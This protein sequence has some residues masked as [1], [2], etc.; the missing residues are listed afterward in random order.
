[1]V[2]KRVNVKDKNGERHTIIVNAGALVDM[3]GEVLGG[4]EMWRDAMPE[5]EMASRLNSL[6]S[7]LDDYCQETGKLLDNL[8][9]VLASVT[10]KGEKDQPITDQMRVQLGVLLKSCHAMQTSYCWS[11][12]NCPPERQVQCPAFPNHG[13][14]CW[15]IDY[16]WCNGQMQGDALAKIDKCSQCLVFGELRNRNKRSPLIPAM[17]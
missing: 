13:R 8:D 12:M 2:G 9:E 4:F 3:S 16:T 14:K 11:I 7:T 6:M 1:V 10:G 5:A 15:D 17:V